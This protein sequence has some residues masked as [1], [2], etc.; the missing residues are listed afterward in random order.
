MPLQFGRGPSGM[1]RCNNRIS[2]VSFYP[3]LK[4]IGKINIGDLAV[5]IGIH[6]FIGPVLPIQIIKVQV[7][8]MVC[9]AG[10]IDD[11]GTGDLFDQIQELT[12]EGKVAQMIGAELELE[13]IG[14]LGIGRHHHTRIV[15][16]QVQSVKVFLELVGK[17]AHGFQVG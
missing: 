13:S 2:T 5:G 7:T 10:H 4:L 6:L 14:G 11:P 15:Y 12:C 17:P 16:E 1:G 8:V 9:G 3:F